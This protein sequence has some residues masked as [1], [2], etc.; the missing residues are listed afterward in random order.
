MDNHLADRLADWA[1]DLCKVEASVRAEFDKVINLA[2]R[3]RRR[4]IAAHAAVLDKQQASTA[5]I[6]YKLPTQEAVRGKRLAAAG[7]A[8]VFG[9]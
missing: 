2:R 4:I 1:A 7:H 6:A 9:A 5:K 8:M 3:V